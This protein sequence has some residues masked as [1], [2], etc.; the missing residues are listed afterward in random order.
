MITNTS[1]QNSLHTVFWQKPKDDPQKKKKQA[2]AAK[3]VNSYENPFIHTLKD[4]AKAGSKDFVKQIFGSEKPLHRNQKSGEMQP[5]QDITITHLAN[6]QQ[7]TPKPE[8]KPNIRSGIEQRDYVGE[9]LR[10]GEE[11]NKREADE[12]K[13]QVEKIIVEIRKLSQSAK[14]LGQKVV[15]ATGPTIVKPGKYHKHF[16]DHVLSI[17]RDAKTKIDNAGSWLSAMQGKKKKGMGRKK[18][19]TNYWD[20]VQK[21]GTK[22]MLSGER[23][24]ATQTGG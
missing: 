20:Q 18:K 9:I 21:H 17:I 12:T 11:A 23:A 15:E 3:R 19:K 24:V 22:Y 1:G 16:L 4:N 6:Q 13:Q 5:G 10:A 14:E 7:E 2:A 8:V